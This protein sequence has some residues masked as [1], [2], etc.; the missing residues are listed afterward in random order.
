MISFMF[1]SNQISRSTCLRGEPVS[2]SYSLFFNGSY[3]FPDD[4]VLSLEQ[5]AGAKR[6]RGGPCIVHLMPATFSMKDLAF[7]MYVDFFEKTD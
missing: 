1:S 3:L 6:S 2:L 7:L 4:P 5:E